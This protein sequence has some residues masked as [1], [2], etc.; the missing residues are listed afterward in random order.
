MKKHIVGLIIAICFGTVIAASL[1]F[2]NWKEGKL[3]ISENRELAHFPQIINENGKVS[4]T[5][6]IE[7]KK[8]FEDNLGFREAYF[9]LSSTINYNLFNKSNANV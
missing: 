7:L 6:F 3:S 2:F 5:L 9:T 4:D 8:W 1:I